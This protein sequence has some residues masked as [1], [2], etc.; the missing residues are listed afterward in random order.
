VADTFHEFWH[1]FA[2]QAHGVQVQ[3]MFMRQGQDG[4]RLAHNGDMRQAYTCCARGRLQHARIVALAQHDVFRHGAGLRDDAVQGF[5]GD[6]NSVKKMPEPWKREDGSGTQNPARLPGSYKDRSEWCR[7]TPGQGPANPTYA[8][9][10]C[11][12]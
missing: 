11:Y 12:T 1:A 10:T 3:R 8:F 7:I 5:H 2:R 4:G 9:D 6:S